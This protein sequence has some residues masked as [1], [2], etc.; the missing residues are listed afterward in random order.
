M[1]CQVP[2]P[3]PSHGKTADGDAPIIHRIV[4]LDCL[5]GF[6]D[7]GLPGKFEGVAK[8][9]IGMEYQGV[10]RSKSPGR[11]L[12]LLNELQFGQPVIPAMQPNVHGKG[13]RDRRIPIFGNH[14]SI[15]LN[16]VVNA[17]SITT[18]HQALLRGP[19]SPSIQQMS[20]T[21]QPI[22]NQP[23][24][25]LQLG[26]VMK[27]T[28]LERRGYSLLINQ[29]IWKVG[30]CPGVIGFDK[31]FKRFI[32]RLQSASQ[33]FYLLIAQSKSRCHQTSGLHA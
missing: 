12:T 14:Q 25:H 27:F 10:G 17:G 19:W 21:R 11:T 18:H 2:A 28:M 30:S 32:K 5:H 24:G 4:S 13:K 1:H 8:P 23:L 16:R 9:T 31:H 33:V 7:I 6:K 29:H 22:L 3:C 20:S 26:H 15:G